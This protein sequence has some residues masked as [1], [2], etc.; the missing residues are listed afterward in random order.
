MKY[1]LSILSLSFLLFSCTEATVYDTSSDSDIS[2]KYNTIRVQGDLIYAISDTDLVTIDKSDETNPQEVDRQFIGGQLENLYL[3]DEALFI[4]SNTDLHIFELKSNG[5]PEM[6]SSTQHAV[7]FDDTPVQ[8]CDPVA[9]EQD[10]AYVTVSTEQPNTD[11]PCG[12]NLTINELLVYNVADLEAP[13]LIQTIE[14][15]APQGI[16]IAGD[17]LY[18]TNL[19]T[20]TD[21]FTIDHKGG[22]TLETRI[23]GASHD[24][25][26]VNNK[27]MIVGQTEINQFDV[28]NVDAI[29]HYGTITL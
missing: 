21:I 13:V 5:L 25:I 9:A 2:G 24:I 16:A 4:G 3:A 15:D 12:P 28:T 26:A 22:V 17:R 6:K 1:L 10:I 7:N 18:V 23:E 20:G 19:F 29:I 11:N 14:M 27:V 8:V